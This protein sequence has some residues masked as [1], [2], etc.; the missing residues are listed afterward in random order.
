MSKPVTTK[1]RFKNISV[2]IYSDAWL[3]EITWEEDK[4]GDCIVTDG[5]AATFEEAHADIIKEIT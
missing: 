1:R 4:D 5:E 3:W 2:A